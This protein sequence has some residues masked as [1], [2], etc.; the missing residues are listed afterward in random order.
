MEG[1]VSTS[2]RPGS[3]LMLPHGYH[4]MQGTAAVFYFLGS[5]D[6][7]GWRP[8]G[9]RVSTVQFQGL[10]ILTQQTQRERER[11]SSLIDFSSESESE[12]ARHVRLF[13]TP[14]TVAHQAPP[15]VGFSRQEYWRGLPFRSP[16]GLPDPGME[17]ESP[18]L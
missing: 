3:L 4:T 16:G 17:L 8:R 18:A 6:P 10:M 2:G 5:T 13:A 14:W 1:G 9:Q 15:S 11:P 7:G 12:V